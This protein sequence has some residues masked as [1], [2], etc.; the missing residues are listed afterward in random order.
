MSGVDDLR[1]DC[2]RCAGLCCT[3]LPFARSSDFAVDKPAGEPCGNLRTD[4]TCSIHA[5]L[6]PAGFPGC[7]VFDCFGAGQRV[8]QELY[9][10]RTWRTDPGLAGQM[11]GAFTRLRVLHEL[12]YYLRAAASWPAARP[13]AGELAAA[14]EA[15]ERLATRAGEQVDVEAHRATVAPLLRRASAL[16]RRPGGLDRAGHELIGA[17]LRRLDLRRADLRNA[18]LLGADLRGADLDRADVLGTD[19][20]GADVRGADLRAAL[21]LTQPQVSAATGDATTRLPPG[22][23]RPPHWPS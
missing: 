2:G 23:D 22:L 14:R 10:G 19:L 1:A 6:R 7:T 4:F 9:G 17:D 16:V 12:S 21:Y 5:R 20:R 3:A 11:F 18:H 13:L 8:V 15:T